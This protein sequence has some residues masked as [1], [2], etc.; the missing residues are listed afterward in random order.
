MPC[1]PTATSASRTSSSLKGLMM[2]MTNFMD[3]PPTGPLPDRY[4][5]QLRWVPRSALGAA[6]CARYRH[7]DQKLSGRIALST[8]DRRKLWAYQDSNTDRSGDE[9]ADDTD[10]RPGTDERT[11][12]LTSCLAPCALRRPPCAPAAIP[13]ARPRPPACRRG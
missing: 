1:T 10:G 12:R 13:P 2:A 7:C 4:S 9:E 8:G 3:L 11:A 5:S 6:G